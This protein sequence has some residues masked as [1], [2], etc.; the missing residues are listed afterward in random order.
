[1]LERVGKHSRGLNVRLAFEAVGATR[2]VVLD[3]HGKRVL[4]E[5]IDA[6]LAEP[7]YAAI[8][9]GVRE[10][11]DALKDEFPRAD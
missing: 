2:P 6:W 4:L 8:P 7:S 9:S 3:T 10:L 11:R 1:L 5:V